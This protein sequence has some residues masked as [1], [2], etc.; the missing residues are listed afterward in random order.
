MMVF[1]AKGGVAMVAMGTLC[2]E[3]GV[4]VGTLCGGMSGL[5]RGDGHPLVCVG[6]VVTGTERIGKSDRR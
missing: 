5:V 3:W 2:S 6:R 4:A 1:G